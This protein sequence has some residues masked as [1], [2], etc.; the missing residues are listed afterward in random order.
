MFRCL[1]SPRARYLAAIKLL[2]IFSRTVAWILAVVI[3]VLSLV[4]HQLR[5]E[6]GL[7]N[8]FEHAGIFA[9][10]GAAF[11][12]SYSRRPNLIMVGLV[13]FAGVIEIAQLLIPGRHAR[14]SDF[15]VDAVSM[16]ATVMVGSIIM[17]RVLGNE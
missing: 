13:I 6:T 8:D 7:S 14:L 3:V 10:T 2:L 17:N 4:P 11:G 15:L 16:C 1:N 12:V 9:I 5:P